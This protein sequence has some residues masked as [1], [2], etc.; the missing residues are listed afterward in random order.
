MFGNLFKDFSLAPIFNGSLE[1]YGLER[2]DLNIVVWGII[3]VFVFD[4]LKEKNKLSYEEFN[5]LALP[6]RWSAYYALILAVI[7]LGAYGE[8]YQAIDLIYAGF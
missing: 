2:M 3:I 6:V 5:K 4:L 8:G 7:I 1:H